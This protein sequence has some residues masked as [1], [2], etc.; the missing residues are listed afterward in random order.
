M[1][2]EVIVALIT[3]V[4]TLAGVVA[5]VISGNRKTQAQIKATSELTQYRIGEL[6]KKQDKHN[7]MIERMYQAEKDINLL[8]EQHSENERRI[9]VLEQKGDGKK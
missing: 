4:F 5:T 2:V 1:S 3:G 6:E 9:E 7:G 8:K